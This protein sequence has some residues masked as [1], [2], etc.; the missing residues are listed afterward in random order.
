[1]IESGTYHL[2]AA[3]PSVCHLATATLLPYSL[4]SVGAAVQ[5]TPVTVTGLVALLVCLIPT[6]IGALL[7]A[8]GIAGMDRMIQKNAIAMAGRAVEAAG[9]V[10]VLVAAQTGTITPAKR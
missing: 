6:T 9:A 7:S 4:Y 5:G 2:D 1:M 10:G 3:L 8:I